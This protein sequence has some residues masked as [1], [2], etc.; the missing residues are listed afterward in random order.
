MP[1][2]LRKALWFAALYAAGV[3]AV[4]VVAFAIRAMIL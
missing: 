1:A 2:P 4:A 3:A